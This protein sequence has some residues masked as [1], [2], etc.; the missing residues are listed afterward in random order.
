MRYII[1]IITLI[2][3]TASAQISIPITPFATGEQVTRVD[4]QFNAPIL[5]ISKPYID[6][7]TGRFGR[8]ISER[9]IAITAI[10]QHGNPIAYDLGMW[11]S[12]WPRVIRITGAQLDAAGAELGL[13]WVTSTGIDQ[14]RI[15]MRAALRAI[16]T[17]FLSE[18]VLTGTITQIEAGLLAQL[19]FGD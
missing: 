14:L 11:S 9:D 6:P 8:E 5:Q 10:N 16:L 2:T 12:D 1:A 17:R 18:P 7:E 15:E 19:G 13:T 3:A 4:I